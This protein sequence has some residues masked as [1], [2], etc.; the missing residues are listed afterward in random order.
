MLLAKQVDEQRSDKNHQQYRAAKSQQHLSQKHGQE[1]QTNTTRLPTS[2]A[3][4][5]QPQLHN[6]GLLLTRTKQSEEEE[7]EVTSTTM[8]SSSPA[9][10]RVRRRTPPA[11]AWSPPHP[12]QAE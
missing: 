8:A 2:E 7:E 3:L 5:M 11:Q 6:H 12:H 9:P 10:S 4:H 1:T